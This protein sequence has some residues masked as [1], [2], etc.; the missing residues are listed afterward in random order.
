MTTNVQNRVQK[1]LN[2]IVARGSE[3]GLQ[4]AAYRKGELIVDAWAGLA[5][6]A[7]GRKVDGHTLF[8]VFSTTKGITA[9]A[10]H[11]LAERGIL[12]YDTPIAQYWPN[13]DR[14]GKDTITLRH[15]LNHTAGLPHMPGFTDVAELTDWRHMCDL[16]TGLTPLW[17][18]G[19]R[20]Y[21][22]AITFGWLVGE[23]ACQVTGLNFSRIVHEEIS[24]PLGIDHSLFIGLP[25]AAES[26]VA[27]FEADPNPPPAPPATDAV[28]PI[29]Q[30]SIP[31]W[32]IRLKNGSTAP[33][34]IRVVFPR[35]TASC[36]PK[37]WPN[38][39]PP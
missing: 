12:Q 6:P 24:K 2:E 32:S 7:T 4:V 33:K 10:I 37:P 21:Y 1:R 11:I 38:T 13:F 14:N 26:R 31:P 27:I 22:H 16:I 36:P 5:D 29:A 39:M 17:P 8:P 25:P 35:P 18:P 28:D 20:T 30:L 34:C 3:Q 19:T 15:A 9:T 23:P